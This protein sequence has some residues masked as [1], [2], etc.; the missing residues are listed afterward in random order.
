[1]KSYFQC[2][3]AILLI[4][5]IF[6][7]GCNSSHKLMKQADEAGNYGSL[8][9]IAKERIN[10]NPNDPYAL[11]MLGKVYLSEGKPDSAVY[12]F[13]SAFRNDPKKVEYQTGLIDAKIVYGDTLLKN[14]SP[15]KARDSY[16]SAI[17]LD[18]TH[19]LALCRTG[20]M[21]R[22]FG[23]Y[24]KA[25]LY[26]RKAYRINTYADSLQKVLDFFD[27][28]HVQSNL[29]MRKGIESLNS[30]QYKIAMESLD[31]AVKAKPDNKEAK[32]HS[33]LANGLY[34]YKRG[35]VGKLWDAIE[36]FGLASAL[37]PEEPEPH[38]YMADA[39]SKKDKKDFENS[40]REFEEVIR[41]APGSKLAKDAQK[42]I[43]KLKTRE[44]L[45][46]DFWNKK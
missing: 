44:K 13:E 17:E 29:L 7:F 43:D 31:Q 35:S 18:S 39:Y 14:N 4:V 8:K 24:D 23:E 32:Y 26:Y 5:T 25:R 15:I 3:K 1:M 41:L 20:L 10:K 30:K 36:N 45:L 38:F 34:Y 12:F 33:F 19:F 22:K 9:T 28:A 27:A 16:V 37:K 21:Y 40:I 2:L 6:V 46:K 11:A 42:K